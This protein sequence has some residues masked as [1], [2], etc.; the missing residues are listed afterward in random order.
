MSKSPSDG[1]RTVPK[2][3]SGKA[4]TSDRSKSPSPGGA[5][6]GSRHT[7]VPHGNRP[8][9]TV[10][11]DHPRMPPAPGGV[12]APIKNT[13]MPRPNAAAT[14]GASRAEGGGTY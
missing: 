8:V 6:G 4:S 1:K 14:S 13:K 7:K 3:R 2:V 5:S 12:K 10:P 11:A 9:P